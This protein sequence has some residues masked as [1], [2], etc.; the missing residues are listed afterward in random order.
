MLQQTPASPTGVIVVVEDPLV[1]RFVGKVLER[2]GYP[3]LEMDPQPALEATRTGEVS[4]RILITNIPHV[5]AATAAEV[6]VLYLAAE[7]NRELMDGYR[8]LS[9]L[10]K[11]FLPAQLLN[12]VKELL[13][14]G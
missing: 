11:P 12:L 9:V 7:P 4:I 8:R 2:A 3:V 10:Q 13:E 5:F 1:S 6:P 14:S